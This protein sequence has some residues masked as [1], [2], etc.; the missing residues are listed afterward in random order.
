MI[1]IPQAGVWGWP[2]HGLATGGVIAGSGKTITQPPNANAWLIDI[3]LPAISLTSAET[4]QATANNYEWRNYALISG[5]RLYDTALP[6]ESFIHVDAD[7]KCWLVTLSYSYP[8]SNTLR[9]TASIKR[10]GLFGHGAASAITKT[11]D[12]ACEAIDPASYDIGIFDDRFHGLED[13]W[14]NGSKAIVCIWLTNRDDTEIMFSACEITLTGAGG[15]NGAGL[16]LSGSEVRG[17]S[18]LNER[19]SDNGNYGDYVCYAGNP[20]SGGSDGWPPLTDYIQRGTYAKY[21]YYNSSGGACVARLRLTISIDSSVISCLAP[22]TDFPCWLDPASNLTVTFTETTVEQVG[23]K[24]IYL[25]ENDTVIDKLEYSEV[26]HYY[27]YYQYPSSYYCA[28]EQAEAIGAA[29]TAWFATR[30]ATTVISRDYAGGSLD[31]KYTAPDNIL[32]FESE[33]AAALLSA[34]RTRSN[35]FAATM[36]LSGGEKLG[37]SHINAKSM[38]LYHPTATVKEWGTIRTPLGNKTYSNTAIAL[39]IVFAWQR[40]TGDFAFSTS[41]ICYV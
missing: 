15:T 8:A 23:I 25:L 26:I 13:V 4:A 16:S 29:V 11:V 5:G 22:T 17:L 41:P 3:G 24:G 20:T 7:D 6:A 35:G 39:P 32:D 37:V 21:A 36:D 12:I 9:V 27:R 19:D 31:S 34:W 14:T 18:D 38:A 33:S 30:P 10:F 1:T 40:K 2:W 28:T